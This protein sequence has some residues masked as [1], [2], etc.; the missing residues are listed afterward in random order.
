MNLIFGDQI[1]YSRNLPYQ[2]CKNY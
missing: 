2:K 1:G